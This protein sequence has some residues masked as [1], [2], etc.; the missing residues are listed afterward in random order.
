MAGWPG[1]HL[2]VRA[3]WWKQSPGHNKWLLDPQSKTFAVAL[4]YDSDDRR[5][6]HYTVVF[7]DH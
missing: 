4:A 1:D 3:G 5:R 6:T 7:G 2:A